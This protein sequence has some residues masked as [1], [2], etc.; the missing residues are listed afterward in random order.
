MFVS[1]GVSGI[2]HILVR[3]TYVVGWNN[4]AC[5]P[6]MEVLTTGN[7]HDHHYAHPL[8]YMSRV[9]I[10]GTRHPPY[11]AHRLKE[12]AGSKSDLESVSLSIGRCSV[13][14]CTSSSTPYTSTTSSST[15]ANTICSVGSKSAIHTLGRFIS[16]WA[17]GTRVFIHGAI[18]HPCV[19]C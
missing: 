11:E 14:S 7:K 19:T 15:P 10:Y 1:S 2:L 13:R 16:V 8:N 5:L 4:R 17:P 12:R 3:F 6:L 9:D 18:C